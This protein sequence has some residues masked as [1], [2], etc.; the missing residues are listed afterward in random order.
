MKRIKLLGL[1]TV[2]MLIMLVAGCSGGGVLTMDLAPNPH[3]SYL[4]GQFNE[5]II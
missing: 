1:T 2:I 3:A 4:A 5:S